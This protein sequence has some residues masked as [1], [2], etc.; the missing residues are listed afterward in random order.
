MTYPW[1]E[2]VLPSLVFLVAALTAQFQ[3]AVPGATIHPYMGYRTR[4]EQAALHSQG[5][6]PLI[7]VN[8]LREKAG[9]P[10]IGP[11]DNKYVITM[12]HPGESTHE[13]DPSRAVDV[14]IMW[15]EAEV[16]SGRADLDGDGVSDYEELGRI[17][18]RLGLM[19][20]GRWGRLGD[21]G[22]FEVPPGG[23]QGPPRAF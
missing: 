16:W 6:K 5:R 12:A 10:P 1:P 4:A 22:H 8:R 18:E 7:E 17:G 3:E 15:G 13:E 9:L 14:V 20:G 11:I 19:W 2:H 23:S 21:V